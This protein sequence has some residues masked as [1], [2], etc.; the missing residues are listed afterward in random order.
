L[1][2]A[3]SKQESGMCKGH[4]VREHMSGFNLEAKISKTRLAMRR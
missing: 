1:K 3:D 4:E 2:E